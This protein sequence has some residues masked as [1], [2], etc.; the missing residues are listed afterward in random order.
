MPH[1]TSLTLLERLRIP[2][3]QEAWSR[4]ARL[5][6]PLLYSWGRRT[7]L[8]EH[9][10]ADVVQEVFVT[11]VRKLPEFQYDREKSFRGW[12]RVVTLNKC[13][14][15]HRRMALQPAGF[16]LGVEEVAGPARDDDLEEVEY[17]RQLVHAALPI[18]EPEF[19]PATWQAFR[20]H[21]IEGREAAS[22]AA[23]LGI[24]VGT[25]YAAKCR[26]LNRLRQ[27]LQG[28]LDE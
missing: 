21:V 26:V 27:E 18:I 6:T 24:R 4:F 13:R 3:D 14:E 5:Y 17:R 15:R 20:L 28:F 23:Q 9:D 1:T 11:L 10:A 7:G 25:V 2:G 16:A 8:S 12:L 19:S 22:V